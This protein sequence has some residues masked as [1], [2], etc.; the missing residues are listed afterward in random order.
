MNQSKIDQIFFIEN[1]NL[2]SLPSR[3]LR[4]GILGGNLEDGLQRLIEQYPQVIPGFQIEPGGEAP[5]QFVL[6]CREMPVGSWSLDFLLVDQHAIPTLVECKLVENPESR[7]AVVGQIIEYA[8]NAAGAW[9]EGKLR[10]KAAEYWSRKGREL[11]EVLNELF[12]DDDLDA[13]AFWEDVEANLHQGK[14]RLIIVTD[15]FRP[16]VRRIIEFL[17][18]ET[19]NIE[20]LG[21]EI[22]CYGGNDAS[23]VLVPRLVGQSTDKPPVRKSKKWSFSEL[24][25]IYKELPNSTLGKRFLKVLEWAHGYGALRETSSVHPTFRL[26]GKSGKHIMCFYLAPSYKGTV[27]CFLNAQKYEGNVDERDRFAKELKTLSTFKYA[28]TKD[29]DVISS[30]AP[31][32]EWSEEEFQPFLEILEEFCAGERKPDN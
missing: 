30:S 5:P 17:N 21:L 24:Q 14:M 8:A 20:I 29:A 4:E 12:D 18:A 3:S 32:D 2:R 27:S 6:L 28:Q 15:E 13:D 9:G 23:L 22:R 16:E 1:E 7:R 10:E 26:N 11:N 19:R 31:I 25:V